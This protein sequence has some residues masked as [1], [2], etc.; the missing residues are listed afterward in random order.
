MKNK[1]VFKK[2][3]SR[4]VILAVIFTLVLGNINVAYAVDSHY[5]GACDPIAR[6]SDY[7]TA[8]DQI[9]ASGT[10]WVRI[11]P[12]W[13]SIETSKGIYN[14]AFLAKLDAI[15]DRLNAG[16]VNVLW[17]LCYTAKWASSEPNDP[18]A[19]RFKPADWSDWESY[20]SYITNRYEGKVKYWE[21]WNEEDYS[22]YWKNTVNDY[23][24]LLQKAYAQVKAT[25]STN[26]VL[27]GAVC[28]DNF[29]PGTWCDNLMSL[30]AGNY[31]DIIN[32]HTYY[33]TR[34]T[35]IK[36]D[37]MQATI[38]NYPVLAAKKI[39]ITETGYTTYGDLALEY[40]KANYLD[41][42]YA[43]YKRYSNVEKIFVYNFR[44]QTNSDTF[45]NNFGI[46][47]NDFSPA[48]GYFSFQAAKGAMT[49]WNIQNN[50]LSLYQTKQTLYYVPATSGDGSYVVTDGNDKKIPSS[51]YMYLRINDQWLYNTNDGV[52]NVA[53]IDVTYKDIGTG[54]FQIQYDGASNKYQ[55]TSDVTKTNTGTYKTATFTVTDAIFINRQNNAS[56]FRIWAK[57]DDLLVSAVTV[58]KQA[59]H[60]KVVLKTN[61]SYKL[62]QH[63]ISADP[64]KEAYNPV[65]T[66]GGIECRQITANNKYF[67]FRVSKGIAQS[68]DTN[69]TIKFKYWDSGTDKI[70]LHYNQSGGNNYKAIDLTKTNTNTWKVASFNITDADF[71]GAQNNYSDFRIYNGSDGSSEY[72]S[73]VE[74]IRN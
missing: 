18:E 41:E 73:E 2:V 50:Y 19:T 12:E 21:V 68:G 56:D 59:E 66:V 48:R 24:T 54:S 16:G 5:F 49:D 43:F 45:L 28:G 7:N 6:Y 29:G 35:K 57:T 15:V 71:K 8:C 13:G 25:D 44:K 64:N 65:A 23:F 60:G 72:V 31:M 10:K 4:F 51:K 33:D 67:Y 14:T 36:Q 47:E 32:Y 30:G 34:A 37:S 53:Y 69:L 27:M 17:V 74:V 70:G 38:N 61:D 58:R 11:S 52:D 9:I 40:D 39:W 63:V 42:V 20:V 3:V 62:M 46:V 1:K 55:T 22:K 26:K